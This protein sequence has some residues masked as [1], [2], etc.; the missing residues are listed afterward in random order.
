MFTAKTIPIPTHVNGHILKTF[1]QLIL[2]IV[3][4]S[5][6]F[7]YRGIYENMFRLF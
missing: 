5:N 2:S 7:L 4:T 6:Q 1:F 3:L